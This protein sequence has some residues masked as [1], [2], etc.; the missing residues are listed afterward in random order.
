M[1]HK[2]R[3]SIQDVTGSHTY[4]TVHRENCIFRA[5]LH[6]VPLLSILKITR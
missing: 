1:K 3:E 4:Y 2:K 5:S 6:D